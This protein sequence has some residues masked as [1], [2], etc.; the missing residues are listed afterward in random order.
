M[1]T[2]FTL[3]MQ[4]RGW[5][6][7]WLW[8]KEEEDREVWNTGEGNCGRQLLGCG[9]GFNVVAGSKDLGKEGTTKRK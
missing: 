1:M 9:G 7:W 8:W 3:E 2:A 6:R 4:S 5:P